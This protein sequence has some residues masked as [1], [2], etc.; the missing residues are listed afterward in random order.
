MRFFLCKLPILSKLDKQSKNVLTFL[1][2]YI[3]VVAVL[4]MSGAKTGAKNMCKKSEVL[5]N[6]YASNI[7]IQEDASSAQTLK[8]VQFKKIVRLMC[9]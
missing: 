9:C 1:S 3:Y 7:C 8:P 4:D 6:L 2:T 5:S